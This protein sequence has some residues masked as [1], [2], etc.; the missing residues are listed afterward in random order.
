[1]AGGISRGVFP[2]IEVDDDCLAWFCG[3][4]AVDFDL[5]VE[6]FVVG[7]DEFE[8]FLFAEDADD[9]SGAAA[10]DFED[11]SAHFLVLGDGPALAGFA[12]G[13]C[14][15]DTDAVSIEGGGG[16][17]AWDEDTGMDCE[18][19]AGGLVFLVGDDGVEEGVSVWQKLD[20]AGEGVSGVW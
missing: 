8:V 10:E 1:M 2:G 4:I 19:D 12:L 9:A 7:F 15:L 3:G 16:F 11:F 14:G 17:I 6:G 13:R 20:G 5:A 18:I